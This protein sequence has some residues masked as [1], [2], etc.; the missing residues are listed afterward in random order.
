[1][2][3]YGESVKRFNF[4][5]G[6]D[7]E[8]LDIWI[9]FIFEQLRLGDQW[10][11]PTAF[12]LPS[13]NKVAMNYEWILLAVKAAREKSGVWQSNKLIGSS[14]YSPPTTC[15]DTGYYVYPFY[16]GSVLPLFW[17]SMYLGM[18]P[19][20]Y[21]LMT[22]ASQNLMVHRVMAMQPMISSL[23]CRLHELIHD[24]DRNT[25]SAGVG[26]FLLWFSHF[27]VGKC[28]KKKTNLRRDGRN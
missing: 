22:R 11:K 17:C 21:I 24:R 13:G 8:K 14:L 20:S 4:S 28:T 15:I 25:P 5:S 7:G 23:R 26:C 1:M 3:S 18:M 27:L 19:R 6:L 9:G 12:Q 2:L 10:K 16:F